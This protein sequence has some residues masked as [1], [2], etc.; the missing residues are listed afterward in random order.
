MIS[1]RKHSLPHQL[2]S[3]QAFK[4][5]F[6]DMLDRAEFSSSDSML[7]YCAGV[8]NGAQ[9]GDDV[10][11]IAAFVALGV[12]DASK[13][14]ILMRSENINSLRTNLFCDCEYWTAVDSEVLTSCNVRDYLQQIVCMI[15]C[16]VA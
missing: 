3:L 12:N 10:K 11:G 15:R 8:V 9:Y 14:A 7:Q 6:V 16:F 4:T 1:V 2:H 5:I 13:M